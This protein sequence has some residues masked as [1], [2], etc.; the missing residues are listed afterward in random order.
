MLDF[1]DRSDTISSNHKPVYF[2]SSRSSYFNRFEIITD[3]L[4]IFGTLNGFEAIINNLN[5]AGIGKIQLT[6]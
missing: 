2:S 6:L 3:A 1:D 4:N 5:D